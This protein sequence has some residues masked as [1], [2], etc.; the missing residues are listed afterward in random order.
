M[1]T[2]QVL[3]LNHAEQC[4]HAMKSTLGT[5]LGHAQMLLRL[6]G[7]TAAAAAGADRSS[8]GKNENNGLLCFTY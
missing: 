2:A 3:V 5:A 6:A 8:T 4:N 1:Q 7:C